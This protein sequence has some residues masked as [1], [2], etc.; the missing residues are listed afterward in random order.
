MEKVLI[1][2]A[3]GFVGQ[4]LS[5]IFLDRGYSVTGL[6]T[7]KTHFLSEESPQFTWVSA[8]TTLEGEW[9]AHAAGADIIINLAGRSIFKYWT[10]KY[11][12]AIHDSRIKTTQNIVSALEKGQTRKLLTTSAVGIYG[13]C[14]DDLLTEETAPGTGFLADVCRNWEGAGIQAREKGVKTAVMRFGVVLGKNGGALATMLPAFKFFAGGPLGG[15][16]QWFPWIHMKDLAVAVAF[17]IEE[18]ELEGVFNFTGPRPV[19]QKEFA[20][21]LGRVLNRPAFMPAP[22]FVVKTIMGELGASLLQSQRARPGN[23]EEAGYEFLFQD[24]ESALADILDKR[25]RENGL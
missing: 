25:F 4:Y 14:G 9:Q 15:G 24:V 22:A 21:S 8:D 7:S 13:D 23:L 18:K 2:G 1:T 19:R 10:P 3:S 11:K 12:Q 16:R 5:R 17:I 6:G 20:R